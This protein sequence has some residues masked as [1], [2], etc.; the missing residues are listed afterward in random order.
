[1]PDL[2][3]ALDEKYRRL[4]A[5][6][7][8]HGRVA[9]AFSGGV[10]SSLLCRAAREALEDGAI[11]ITL[12][13]PMM[14]ADDLAAARQ[15]AA[16]TGIAH[17]L[18]E[19]TT[20]DAPVA[21]NPPDRCYH[22]KKVEFARI[23]QLAANH[24]IQTVLDGTNLDDESDYRPG[25]RALAEL[26]VASPFREAGLAK[27]DGLKAPAW[28]QNPADWYKMRADAAAAILAAAK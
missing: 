16:L 11:A 6:I 15:I 12:V 28:S 18:I 20:I 19:E 22:C 13:S 3:P 23:A 8:R 9:V 25:M 24:G 1:M 27:A 21:A 17:F 5:A 2:T 10:D 14:P 26:R 4:L 7:A